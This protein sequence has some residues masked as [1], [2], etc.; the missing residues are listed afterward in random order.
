MWKI[1]AACVLATTACGDGAGPSDVVPADIAGT[2]EASPG[3]LPQCGVTLV[4]IG[5][6]GDTLNFVSEQGITFHLT[7][8]RGGR[9]DL[10]PLPQGPAVSGRV[11]VEGSLLILRDTDG[12]TDTV[13]LARTGEYL[14]LA[15]RGV[16]ENFDFDG[17]FVA[18]PATIRAR[19][20]RR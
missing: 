7:L 15:F 4:R 20:R 17:D 18:D 6:P 10:V 13:D 5:V 1:V 14:D 19:F 11:E 12:V 9:F 16:S 2:W 3:C 8:T